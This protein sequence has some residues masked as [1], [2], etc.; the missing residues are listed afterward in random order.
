MFPETL[1]S[2]SL[3]TA[4]TYLPPLLAHPKSGSFCHSSIPLALS[5]HLCR[6]ESQSLPTCQLSKDLGIVCHRRRQECPS[7]VA[8]HWPSFHHTL[9]ICANSCIDRHLCRVFCHLSIVLG[10]NRHLAKSVFQ[11]RRKSPHN[12][13]RL[14]MEVCP[15]NSRDLLR[16]AIELPS[17]VHLVMPARAFTA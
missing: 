10:N 2:I 11:I 7:H 5:L 1:C 17:I 3:S 14:R 12:L 8:C 16:I 13:C 15:S 9:W 4:A 6:S